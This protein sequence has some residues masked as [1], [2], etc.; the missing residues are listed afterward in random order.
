MHAGRRNNPGG[1]KAR[2]ARTMLGRIGQPA[3]LAG[4]VVL[5]A[6]D[7]AAYITGQEIY[8]DGG[9]LARGF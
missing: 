8:V 9:W 4:I 7:A 3:E 2:V 6:S 5:R 1:V